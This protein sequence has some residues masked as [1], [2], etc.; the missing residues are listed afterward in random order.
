[1]TEINNR[2]GI[3]YESIEEAANFF[4]SVK[5]NKYAHVNSYIVSKGL[6][7][8][9]DENKVWHDEFEAFRDCAKELKKVLKEIPN[10]INVK[11]KS[12]SSFTKKNVENL[13]D[14]NIKYPYRFTIACIVLALHIRDIGVAEEIY[15]EAGFF[16]TQDKFCEDIIVRFVIAHF[17]DFI[18][19]HYFSNERL[20]Q[21]LGT[22]VIV[23]TVRNSFINF[24]SEISDSK[25]LTDEIRNGGKYKFVEPIEKWI[26]P[27]RDE[28]NRFSYLPYELGKEVSGS[29]D[30]GEIPDK[31]FFSLLSDNTILDIRKL[32]SLPNRFN[33]MCMAVALELD[34]RQS[35]D[36]YNSWGFELTQDQYDDDVLL[37]FIVQNY[38]SL[39][40]NDRR[41]YFL[42]EFNWLHQYKYKDMEEEEKLLLHSWAEVTG[43]QELIQEIGY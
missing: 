32:K 33:L 2:E 28:I 24:Y 37:C 6:V 35:K 41:V 38:D 7:K 34:E 4:K 29:K 19:D 16:L 22:Y 3:P 21:F 9:A 23:D 36:L 30:W 8:D 18:E 10:N 5:K 15:R 43:R 11:P 25:S 39:V 31:N 40:D 27:H 42:K 17:D 14:G 20:R 26:I 1:M 13:A 12:S